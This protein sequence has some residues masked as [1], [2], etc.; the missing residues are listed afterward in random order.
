MLSKV[1]LPLLSLFACAQAQSIVSGAAWTDTSGNPIQAHGAGILKA[2]HLHV[3]CALRR[4]LIP[5]QQVGST[6]YWFGEDKS[7]N[8]ALFKA[9]SCYSVSSVLPNLCLTCVLT[10]RHRFSRPTS[11]T[12]RAR[13]MP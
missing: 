4:M 1:L 12:G 5:K 13:T 2:S 9:V 8:S 7:A 6:F 10:P 3:Y 11:C